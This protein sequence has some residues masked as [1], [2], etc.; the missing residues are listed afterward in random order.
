MLNPSVY[1]EKG[2]AGCG[3]T[4]SASFRTT[5][6]TGRLKRADGQGIQQLVAT[7][8]ATKAADSSQGCFAKGQTPLIHVCQLSHRS[9]LY[10][11]FVGEFLDVKDESAWH[12]Y[13]YQR[14]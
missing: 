6:Q 7:V 2:C 4:L 8:A 9:T 10:N 12:E 5:K 1:T 11:V 14:V 3:S 13:S